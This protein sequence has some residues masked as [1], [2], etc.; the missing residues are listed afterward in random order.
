MLDAGEIIALLT[1]V[2]IVGARRHWCGHGR[3]GRGE[4]TGAVVTGAAK[5]V[6]RKNIKTV[7]CTEVRETVLSSATRHA[8]S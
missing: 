3:G 1:E 6:V 7:T 4:T 2:G 5:S 8:T